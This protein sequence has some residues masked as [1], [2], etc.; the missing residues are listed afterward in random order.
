MS[1][2]ATFPLRI[3]FKNLL[4]ENKYFLFLQWSWEKSFLSAKVDDLIIYWKKALGSESE[5]VYFDGYFTFHHFLNL[6][7]KTWKNTDSLKKKHGA[8]A[9]AMFF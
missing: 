8:T 5:S 1:W 4:D 3:D 9:P 6:V 2:S 7:K